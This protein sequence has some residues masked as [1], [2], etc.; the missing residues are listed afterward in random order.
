[1]SDRNKAG[2]GSSGRCEGTGKGSEEGPADAQRIPP[3][4]TLPTNLPAPA[5]DRNRPGEVSGRGQ[6]E[7]ACA[8]TL[9]TPPKAS[10][11]FC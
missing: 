7:K 9:A 1:M 5:V 3:T 4:G 2:E 11:L 10:L 8:L 6:G